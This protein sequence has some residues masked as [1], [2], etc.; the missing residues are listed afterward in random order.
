MV[1]NVRYETTL[2]L[3]KLASCGKVKLEKYQEVNVMTTEYR[4]VPAVGGR[5]CCPFTSNSLCTC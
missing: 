5:V 2:S 4:F 1:G 3:K